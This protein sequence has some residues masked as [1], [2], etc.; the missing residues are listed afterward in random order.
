VFFSPRN[1]VVPPSGQL[2]HL[3]AVV[4]RPDHDRVVGDAEVVDLLQHLAD[5]PVVLDHAVGI[6][7]EAGLALDS[8]LRCVKMCMRVGVEPH[9]ERLLVGR[10]SCR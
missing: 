4:G 8:G 7:S 10:P 1:G 3:G 2:M 5:V 6:G 9:E